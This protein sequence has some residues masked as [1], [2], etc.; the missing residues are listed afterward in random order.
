MTASVARL[1]RITGFPDWII[2]EK[3]S[4]TS[5]RSLKGDKCH[6]E[7]ECSCGVQYPIWNCAEL[8]CRVSHL[9][10]WA[11][12]FVVMMSFSYFY[13]WTKLAF[14]SWQTLQGWMSMRT[15]KPPRLVHLFTSTFLYQPFATCARS[16]HT[17]KAPRL[18]QPFR[19][20]TGPIRSLQA[21]GFFHQSNV[22]GPKGPHLLLCPQSNM[23]FYPQD[24]VIQRKC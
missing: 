13:V 11:L 22:V 12:C 3:L 4:I 7:D 2:R 14:L 6:V 5:W 1:L 8:E 18:V 9:L 10:F 17:D 23:L 20:N 15:D 21:S 16:M 19:K 24:R